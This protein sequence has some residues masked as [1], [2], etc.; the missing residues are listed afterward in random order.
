MEEIKEAQNAV[1]T[2]AD[3]LSSVVASLVKEQ[4]REIDKLINQLKKGIDTF[5]NADLRDI[6]AKISVETYFLSILKEQSSLRNSCAEA[7]Y[8]EG[9]AKSY[10]MA[11]GTQDAR[12]NQS[13]LDNADKQAVSILYNTVN[14]RTSITITIKNIIILLKVILNNSNIRVKQIRIK[15]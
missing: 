4:T 1:D 15:R 6:M 12:R 14:K 9:L 2:V 8:K 7:L 3:E 10:S 5:S 11:A 13:T